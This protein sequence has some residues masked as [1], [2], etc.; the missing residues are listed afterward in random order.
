MKKYSI[1]F[2]GTVVVGANT[3]IEALEAANNFFTE[4]NIVKTLIVYTEQ[5]CL[6]CG[7][8]GEVPADED[9][10]EGHIANGT[11]TQKCVCQLS[12]NKI[13]EYE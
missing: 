9:D 13:A 7:G 6:I 4:N 1:H 11:L 8:T 3:E 10:G 5:E 2:R 12:E